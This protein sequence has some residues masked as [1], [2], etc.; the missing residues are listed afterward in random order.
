MRRNEEEERKARRKDRL[1]K[2]PRCGRTREINIRCKR[3]TNGF[4][5][6]RKPGKKEMTEGRREKRNRRSDKRD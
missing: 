6:T 4:G 1:I 3:K 2:L 5:R